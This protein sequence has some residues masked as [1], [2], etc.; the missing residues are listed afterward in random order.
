M[1]T[2]VKI[3]TKGQFVDSAGKPMTQSLFLEIGY[4]EQ[5]VYTLKDQDYLYEGK[6]YPSLKK[7]YLQTEDPTEY[8]FATLY[9]LN[10]RHWQRLCENKVLR[11]HIDEWRDE[12]EVKLRS[13]G[14]KEVMR[15]AL[16]GNY[17]AAKF[18]ADRGWDTRGAGRPS[19][20][21]VEHEKKIQAA[22]S[23]EYSAD[24]VRLYKDK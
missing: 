9:L 6:W 20:A 24:V 5:A 10:W 17:Q 16:A 19:K 15:S 2:N 3:P 11:K 13:K 8:E 21:E 12:L 22:M 14:V 23:D 4:T 18:L 7:L 1:E